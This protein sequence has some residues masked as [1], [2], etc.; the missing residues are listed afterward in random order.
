MGW[1]AVLVDSDTRLEQGGPQSLSEAR[2]EALAYL[3]DRIARLGPH[4][5]ATR[6]AGL[7][8]ALRR[9]EQQREIS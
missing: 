3:E 5:P 6:C 8:L 4:D 2:A 1:R 7:R 9:V